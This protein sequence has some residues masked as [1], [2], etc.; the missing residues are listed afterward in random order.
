MISHIGQARY[1]W[2][3]RSPG[4]GGEEKQRKWEWSRNER[5]GALLKIKSSTEA[6]R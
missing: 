3:P 4:D 1:L 2:G 5:P 6:L